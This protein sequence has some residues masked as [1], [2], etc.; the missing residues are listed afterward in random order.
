MKPGTRVRWR[1]RHSSGF[2]TYQGRKSDTYHLVLPD[3]QTLISCRQDGC[4]YVADGEFEAAR[5]MDPPKSG[6]LR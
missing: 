4:L 6:A 3:E 1:M 2:G 5:V